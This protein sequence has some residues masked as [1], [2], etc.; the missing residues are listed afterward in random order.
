MESMTGFAQGSLEEK[1]F[2]FSVQ[3]KSVNARF[4]EQKF[5]APKDL[6]EIENSF[7]A[8]VK[9]SVPRGTVEVLIKYK[10]KNEEAFESLKKKKSWVEK[11]QKTA[12]ELGVRDDLT[13]GSLVKM[14]SQEEPVELSKT[15]LNKITKLFK[16]VLLSLR[17]SRSLEGRNLLKVLKTELKKIN[18]D[19]KKLESWYKKHQTEFRKDWDEKVKKIK[20]EIDPDRLEQEI[21]ILLEKGDIVEEIDRFGIHLKEFEKLLVSKE[22]VIGKKLDFYCQEL[23]REANTVG[24]KSKRADLTRLSVNLK[25]SVEKLRQQVQNIQ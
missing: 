24:S 14:S 8:L 9:E 1:K 10:V 19:L 17:K 4:L 21:S 12:K 23:T 22:E 25:S 6:I 3:I 15:D 18:E 13:L 20:V 11:Y 2:S 7:R 16:S 5:Y